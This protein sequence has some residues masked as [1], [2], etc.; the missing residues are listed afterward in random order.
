MAFAAD[1]VAGIEVAYVGADL[2]DLP[3]EFV[4]DGHGNGDGF[5]RPVV[6]LVDVDIGAADAGVADTDQY[7]VDADFG[8]GNFFEPEARLSLAFD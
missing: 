6:P 2:D 1:D 8:F 5:L 7:I 3:D 4:A